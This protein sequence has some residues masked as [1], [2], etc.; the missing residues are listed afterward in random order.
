MCIFSV[1][2]LLLYHIRRGLM[3]KAPPCLI[4]ITHRQSISKNLSHVGRTVTSQ[5]HK[6]VLIGWGKQVGGSTGDSLKTSVDVSDR[7]IESH[8]FR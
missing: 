3:N 4:H 2:F 7:F 8:L 1:P 5:Q 6:T